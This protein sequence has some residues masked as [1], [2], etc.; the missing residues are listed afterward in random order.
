MP[1][2]KYVTGVGK[3][4]IR[5]PQIV[6]DYPAP[7]PN[8]PNAPAAII[9]FIESEAVTLVGGKVRPL[10]DLGRQTVTLRPSDFATAI[11]IVHPDTDADLANTTV[12]NVA[13]HIL[14]AVRHFQRIRDTPPPPPPAPAPAPEPD[15]APEPAP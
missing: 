6:I 15:P 12:Q 4:H 10:G 13:A 3:V 8:D 1:N 14:A 2:E 5:V 7:D 11:K 9:Q